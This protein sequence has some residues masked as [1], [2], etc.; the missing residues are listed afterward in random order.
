MIFFADFLTRNSL[1]R[2]FSFYFWKRKLTFFFLLLFHFRYTFDPFFVVG[3]AWFHWFAIRLGFLLV[4]FTLAD[5]GTSSAVISQNFLVFEI[6]SGFFVFFFAILVRLL[7][8]L[9]WE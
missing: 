6:V 1:T 9:S 8:F 5:S 4:A 7:Y 3:V 2:F